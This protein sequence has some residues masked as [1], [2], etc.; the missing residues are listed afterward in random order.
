MLQIVWITRPEVHLAATHNLYG[1]VI[2]IEHCLL[3][4]H[5]SKEITHLNRLCW[6]CKHLRACARFVR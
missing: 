6:L 5:T 1:I 4:Y 2:F 3:L